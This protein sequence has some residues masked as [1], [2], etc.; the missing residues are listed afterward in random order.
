MGDSTMFLGTNETISL[1]YADNSIIFRFTAINLKGSRN[2]KYKYI[3]DGYEK[4]WQT[5]TD[6]RE[7]RY[8]SLSPG[9]YTFSVKA[10]I[11]G[12]NWIDSN[13]AITLTIIA[14]LW[15]RW[16]FI[17]LVVLGI[18]SIVFYIIR[19][20]NMKL[21]HQREALETEQAINYF[22]T[23]LNEHQTVDSILWDVA[24]NCIGRLA[25]SKTV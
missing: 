4:Q 12:E 9:N 14:P 23:S 17:C 10:S 3:L 11:D 19:N 20:R 5:G 2:I 22:A 25:I 6:I 7:A 21:K 15:Q 1:D 8:S 16:W 24:R 18:T 13:N